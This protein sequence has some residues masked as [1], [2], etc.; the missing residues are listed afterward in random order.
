MIRELR[1]FAMHFFAGRPRHEQG[2]SPR[3]AKRPP[4]PCG[5]VPLAQVSRPGYCVCGVK[6]RRHGKAGRATAA[7]LRKADG[8]GPERAGW[9]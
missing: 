8:L 6:V 7:A 4:E 2:T 9:R 1:A 3:H 5:T